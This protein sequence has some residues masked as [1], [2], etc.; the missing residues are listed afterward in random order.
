MAQL[1]YGGNTMPDPEDIEKTE[2]K[3]PEAAAPEPTIEAPQPEVKEPEADA[4]KPSA[5]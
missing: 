3:K 5:A 4:E 1:L 2:E